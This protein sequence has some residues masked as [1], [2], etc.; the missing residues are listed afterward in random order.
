MYESLK[1]DTLE[2]QWSKQCISAFHKI[3]YGYLEFDI[4]NYA[5]KKIDRP[6]QMHNQQYQ[7]NS[8]FISMSQFSTSFF[9]PTISNWNKLPQSLVDIT[10]P[11]IFITILMEWGQQLQQEI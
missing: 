7:S 5:I 4:N 10:D 2:Q 9:P 1:W 6:Q 11:D 8:N 3:L